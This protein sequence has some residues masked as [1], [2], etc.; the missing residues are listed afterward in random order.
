MS[1]VRFTINPELQTIFDDDNKTKYIF[2][3][4]SQGGGGGG[5]GG[6]NKLETHSPIYFIMDNWE[7]AHTYSDCKDR[8]WAARIQLR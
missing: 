8:L 4:S 3:Q 2:S 1:K 6:A 5:G 7:N